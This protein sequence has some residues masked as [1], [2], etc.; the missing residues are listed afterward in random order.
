MK[1]L[2][3]KRQTVIS[4]LKFE[5]A[6]F[7]PKATAAIKIKWLVTILDEEHHVLKLVQKDLVWL[8]VQK[9]RIKLSGSCWQKVHWSESFI[10][11]FFL[12]SC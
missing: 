7:R 1:Y 12:E 6:G 4:P 2:A 5:G 8:Q 10:F 3:I 11:I 9:R